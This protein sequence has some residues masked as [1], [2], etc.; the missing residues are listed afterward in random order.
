MLKI[1]K[2]L[3]CFLLISKAYGDDITDEELTSNVNIPYELNELSR[4]NRNELAKLEE[5]TQ[6]IHSLNLSLG[7][8][9]TSIGSTARFI[10]QLKVTN[11]KEIGSDTAIRYAVVTLESDPDFSSNQGVSSTSNYRFEISPIG[12]EFKD[13]TDK[14]EYVEIDTLNFSYG[15]DSGMGKDQFLTISL[16]KLNSKQEIDLGPVTVFLK[17]CF[18]FVKYQSFQTRTEG[19]SNYNQF[20]YGGIDLQLGVNF[21]DNLNLILGANV[22]FSSYE[23][24]SNRYQLG[25]EQKYYLRG[26]MGVDLGGSKVNVFTEGGYRSS[27]MNSEAYINIGV[28]ANLEYLPENKKKKGN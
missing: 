9:A 18:E 20:G 19:S 7:T 1:T 24:S 21:F 13:L 3:I 15:R 17:E 26:E 4:K 22:Q 8:G 2:L 16:V 23:N 27:P 14:L 25:L 5:Y 10:V 6:S 12:I 11:K 28:K